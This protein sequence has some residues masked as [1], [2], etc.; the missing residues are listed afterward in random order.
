MNMPD[1]KIVPVHLPEDLFQSVAAMACFERLTLPR[2]IQ[3]LIR[4]AVDHWLKNRNQ[5]GTS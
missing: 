1:G 3:K 2:F 4:Q 5:G